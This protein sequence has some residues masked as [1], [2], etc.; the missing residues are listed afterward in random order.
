MADRIFIA[1][2]NSW[3]Y[4]EEAGPDV[5]PAFTPPDGST[6]TLAE[7]VLS[8]G[9]PSAQ[10]LVG[11]SP[12]RV[13]PATLGGAILSSG[14]TYAVWLLI[15]IGPVD[16]SFLLDGGP[17]T[18]EHSEPYDLFGTQPDGTSGREA[19]S[20]GFHTVTATVSGQIIA[21]ATF[22]VE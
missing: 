18:V 13:N 20:V 19:F 16:V 10:I 14:C 6:G 8:G 12:H 11:R 15:G 7:L 3:G 17:A 21:T 9:P 1:D 5:D 22:E 4:I 2:D